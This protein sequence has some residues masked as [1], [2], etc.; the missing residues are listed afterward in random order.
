MCYN[1]QPQ[2]ISSL[3]VKTVHVIV[4]Y[5]TIEGMLILTHRVLLGQ[6]LLL[7]CLCQT[8]PLARK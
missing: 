2:N 7:Q 6:K 1:E 3:I 8:L 5:W 4:Q